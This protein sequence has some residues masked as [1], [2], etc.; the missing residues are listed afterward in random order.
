MIHN[1]AVTIV[2]TP[3]LNS[4]EISDWETLG[5]VCSLLRELN[6]VHD[7]KVFVLYFHRITEPR[8]QGISHR[9]LLLFSESFGGSYRNLY[10]ATSFWGCIGPGRNR[11]IADVR[12]RELI[13][14]GQ[15]WGSLISKGAKQIRIPETVHESQLLLLRLITQSSKKKP[16]QIPRKPIRLSTAPAK[17]L[18]TSQETPL[19]RLL[20]KFRSVTL[21]NLDDVRAEH[22]RQRQ[23][24]LDVHDE[25]LEQS[26]QRRKTI[27]EEQ[28]RQC[29]QY[30]LSL[31]RQEQALCESQRQKSDREFEDMAQLQQ[32]LA[33]Q[34]LDAD[35]QFIALSTTLSTVQGVQLTNNRRNN[36]HRHCA[37][38]TGDLI[39]LQEARDMKC[40]VSEFYARIDTICCNNCYRRV[41]R[42]EEYFGE[43]CNPFQ[44]EW[45]KI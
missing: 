40:T 23:E 42:N 34:L 24:V 15:F 30:I 2:D 6:N 17:L 14:T 45:K 31:Q 43:S 19:A 36:W 39:A 9:N 11:H 27:E 7:R 5:D 12:E 41:K 25:F 1:E 20:P 35:R 22:E 32:Q 4:G 16:P 3:G 10:L 18:T 38:V 13:Q 37:R 28:L 8:F 29:E 44:S 26:M 21:N 33:E